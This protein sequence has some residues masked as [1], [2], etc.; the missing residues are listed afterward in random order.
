VI[1]SANKAVDALSPPVPLE[2]MRFGV[3]HTLRSLVHA[4]LR[5]RGADADAAAPDSSGPARE[6]WWRSPDG[7]LIAD[8]L[9]P[10]GHPPELAARLNVVPGV[11]EHGLFPPQMVSLILIAGE[12]GVAWRAGAKR[13][14]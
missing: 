9:G 2:L 4:Q 6:R 5:P 12:Q 8:Y 14:R 7:G 11:V 13:D 10:V 3:K 1:A